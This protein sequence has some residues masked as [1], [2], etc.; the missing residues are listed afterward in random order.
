MAVEYLIEEDI[1]AFKCT[2]I[3]KMLTKNTWG[4]NLK[5]SAVMFLDYVGNNSPLY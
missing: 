5:E 4:E 1:F 3:L 2:L